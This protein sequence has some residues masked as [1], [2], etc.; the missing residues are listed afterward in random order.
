MGRNLQLNK[1]AVLSVERIPQVFTYNRTFS[2]RPSLNTD[3]A[4]ES[5]FPLQGG[6]F[7][8]PVIANER[9][10][11]SVFHQLHCLVIFPPSR[12]SFPSLTVGIERHSNSILD[13]S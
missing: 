4:W 2:E 10:A 5:I 13:L 8:H 3:S 9:S 11:F 6:F 12:S 1:Y 7:R